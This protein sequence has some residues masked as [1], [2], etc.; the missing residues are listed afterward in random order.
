M[1]GAKGLTTAPC[2]ASRHGTSGRR[3][4]RSFRTECA[5][6]ACS[7]AM[8]ERTSAVC[9]R[10]GGISRRRRRRAAEADVGSR[11]FVQILS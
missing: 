1:G 7:R 4:R 11:A 9:V 6:A 3:R 10:C 5:S 8:R 2:C